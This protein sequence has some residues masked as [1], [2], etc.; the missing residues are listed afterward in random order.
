MVENRANP[1]LQKFTVD[2]IN[3][4]STRTL[5]ATSPVAY[6]QKNTSDA[7]WGDTM[8]YGYVDTRTFRSSKEQDVIT[9]V[10]K[11]ELN[12]FVDKQI[13]TYWAANSLVSDK[14]YPVRKTAVSG[15]VSRIWVDLDT[16]DYPNYPLIQ[17]L[18]WHDYLS[19][20]QGFGSGT[21]IS[22]FSNW[23]SGFNKV[24]QGMTLT[25][26]YFRGVWVS[27]K[28]DAN[29]STNLTVGIYSPNNSGYPGTLVTSMTILPTNISTSYSYIYLNFKDNCDK[30][31]SLFFNPMGGTNAAM[32]YW[33]VGFNVAANQSG[34]N[35]YIQGMTDREMARGYVNTAS[36][37]STDNDPAFICMWLDMERDWTPLDYRTQ[38]IIDYDNKRLFFQ[39]RD[40]VVGDEPG[41]GMFTPNTNSTYLFPWWDGH[42]VCR[43]TYW[44]GALTTSSALFKFLGDKCSDLYD[45]VNYSFSNASYAAKGFKVENG[46]AYDVLLEFQKVAP[47]YYRMYLNTSGLRVLSIEDELGPGNWTTSTSSYQCYRTFRANWNESSP[48][49]VVSIPPTCEESKVSIADNVVVLGA[50]GD[51]LGSYGSGHSGKTAIVELR[52]SGASSADGANI[53]QNIYTYI[54]SVRKVGGITVVPVDVSN[55]GPLRT[56]NDIA[57]IEMTNRNMSDNIKVQAIKWTWAPSVG[58][59][60]EFDWT[61]IMDYYT[62]KTVIVPGSGDMP[63]EKQWDGSAIT[64]R[65]GGLLRPPPGPGNNRPG[66]SIQSAPM[67]SPQHQ[68]WASS[69]QT[70]LHNESFPIIGN[71]P[72]FIEIGIGQPNGSQLQ[73]KRARIPAAVCNAND[74]QRTLSAWCDY[75]VFSSNMSGSTI[76]SEVAVGNAEDI[77]GTNY[78]S[79]KAWQIFSNYS[80]GQW[81]GRPEIFRFGGR[82]YINLIG[83]ATPP[84]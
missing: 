43:A 56:A 33:Y 65:L 69:Y 77:A 67:N 81:W 4:S 5:I 19:M 17:V 62:V 6:Y 40:S 49:G 71:G 39:K 34:Y 2:L 63:D 12:K 15:T 79:L 29:M 72:W 84:A 36:A 70:M 25:E 26:G 80:T 38:Y 61:S 58:Y 13:R 30:P 27:M 16:D 55:D 53:A 10:C 47:I 64:G 66:S 14:M 22:I 45:L 57:R 32:G 46:T 60:V 31:D 76:I 21:D 24:Y 83:N 20:R 9:L 44:K 23:L 82:L 68:D 73:L 3:T 41:I 78:S 51:I 59:T 75:T 7:G 1:G 52:G 48:G 35:Y 50:D 74:S 11:A 42:E 8:F 37:G 54:M 28:R 18:G